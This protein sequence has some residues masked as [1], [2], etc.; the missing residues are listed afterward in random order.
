MLAI[1]L[2]TLPFFAIVGIGY[3]A[4]KI[5]FFDEK[6]TAYLNKFV[7][8]FALSAMILKFSSQL[9]LNEILNWRFLL[10][11]FLANSVVYLIVIGASVYRRISWSEAAIEAHTAVSGNLGFIGLPML[12][13]IMGAAAVA[14][15][16]MII[17]IDLV[18]FGSLVVIIITVGKEGA[19]SLKSLKSIG[20]AL[21]KNPM[22]MSM[23]A[24]LLWSATNIPLAVPVSEFLSLLGAAATPCALFAIGA[25][26]APKSAERVSVAIW[27]TTAKLIL[28]P[29]V[30]AIFAFWVFELEPFIASVMVACAAIPVAGNV[31]LTAQH[32]N[33]AP[34]RVSSAILV[35]TVASI[36]TLS[37]ALSI[38]SN[39]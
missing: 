20:L 23:V 18:V 15:I 16:L 26:L 34:A 39:G 28:H 30:C 9:A 27:I 3:F 17:I 19:L 29:C 24:G 33:V 7:F 37:I 1:F 6:A 14:P 21:V 25:S 31:Y 12:V 8:Y 10:A 38:V 5:R 35:S 22:I 11:Y 32:Y 36:V 2:K 13:L 4:G